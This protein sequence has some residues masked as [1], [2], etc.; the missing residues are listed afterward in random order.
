M[1]G[2]PLKIAT[3]EDLEIKINAY[4]ADCDLEYDRRVFKHDEIITVEGKKKQRLC[5]SCGSPERSRG[6]LWISGERK[7]KRPYTVS[8]L[9]LWLDTTRQT[10]LEYQGEV[11]GREKTDRRFADAVTRAKQRIENFASEKLFDPNTP[12][13]GIMFSLSNNSDGWAEKREIRGFNLADL[14]KQQEK[15]R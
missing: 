14:I 12:T 1:Q 8:G 13:R 15:N 2:R 3:A 10:L 7:E 4:F 5:A 9:A 11:E 6:C